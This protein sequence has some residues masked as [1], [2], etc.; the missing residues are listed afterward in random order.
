MNNQDNFLRIFTDGSC[1]TNPGRGGWAFVVL[2]KD[3]DLLD[4]GSGNVYYTTNNRME[5]TA[6]IKGIQFCIHNYPEY[7]RYIIYSDSTYVVDGIEGWMKGWAEKKWNGVKNTDLWKQ[8]HRLKFVDNL[9]IR[10]KHVRGHSGNIHNEM[11]DELAG[12][13]ARRE[14]PNLPRLTPLEERMAMDE[15]R[16]LDMEFMRRLL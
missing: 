14:M 3:Y 10:A 12:I 1:L 5:L 8:V 4:N 11:A 2:T 16:N 7:K 6:V 9:N 13:A 15:S